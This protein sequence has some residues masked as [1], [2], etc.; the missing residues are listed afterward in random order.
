MLCAGWEGRTQ[1]SSVP[2]AGGAVLCPPF[3]LFFK[4]CLHL[5]YWFLLRML[6][7]PAQETCAVKQDSGVRN[8]FQCSH[9]VVFQSKEIT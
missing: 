3:P 9:A 2:S 8:P 6:L 4:A 7:V 1:G 5:T